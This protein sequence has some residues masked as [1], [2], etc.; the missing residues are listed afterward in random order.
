MGDPM[1]G[2]RGAIE[3]ISYSRVGHQQVK[4]SM[5]DPMF[6]AREAVEWISYSRVGHLHSERQQG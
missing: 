4:D 6:G 3:W 1:F 2:A 5:G